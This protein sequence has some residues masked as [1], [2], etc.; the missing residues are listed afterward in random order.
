MRIERKSDEGFGSSLYITIGWLNITWTK[1][2][3][4]W[5]LALIWM[6]PRRKD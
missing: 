3:D 4:H 2:E 6:R 1:F 5:Y